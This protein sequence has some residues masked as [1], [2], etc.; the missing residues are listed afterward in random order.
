VTGQAAWYDL[1]VSITKAAPDEAGET[2]PIMP[3]I[4]RPPGLGAA[5][6]ES[7]YGEQFRR[8]AP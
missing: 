1:R 7:R 6:A 2:A 3:E 4:A 5:P 8:K